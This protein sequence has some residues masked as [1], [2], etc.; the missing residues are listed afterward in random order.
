MFV[1]VKMRKSEEHKH[2]FKIY[3]VE[4]LNKVKVNNNNSDFSGAK[5]RRKQLVHK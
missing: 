4:V 2:I 5:Y 3:K 1:K